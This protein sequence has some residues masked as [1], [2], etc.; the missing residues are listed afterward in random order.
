M[1]LPSTQRDLAEL[2]N[3]LGRVPLQRIRLHPPPGTATERD[4]IE[5]ERR[6]NRLC[7]LVDGV[8]VEKAV[9]FIESVLAGAILAALREFVV[10]R[11]LGHVTG[12]DG[13]MRLAPG[14]VR[15]PDAAF[16][17]WSHFPGGRLTDEPI[18]SLAPDLAVEVLSQTNSPEEMQRKRQDYFR[19]G[20]TLVWIVDPRQRTVSVFTSPDEFH[21]VPADQTLDGGTVLPGFSLDLSQVFAE[22]DR[23]AK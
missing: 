19:A 3:Q 2:M 6:E 4:V 11:N 15:I 16:I 7:E 12:A 5:T 9:G 23:Q 8:L 14:L 10:A 22:L 13:T 21:I 1:A 20:T 18:P 17:S